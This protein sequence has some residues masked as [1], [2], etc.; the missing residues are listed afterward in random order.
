MN[1][2]SKLLI[3]SFVVLNIYNWVTIVEIRYGIPQI[4]KYLLSVF[5]LGVIFYYWLKHR[6][7]SFSGGM[8]KVL[9]Y[10]LTFW[11]IILLLTAILEFDDIFYV[12]RLL[13]QRFFYIPYILPLLLLFSKF[14]LIFFR[15]YFNLSFLF[16]SIATLMQVYIMMSGMDRSHWFEQTSRIFI[17][18][19]GAGCLLLTSH[20]TRKKYVSYL[21]VFYIICFVFIWTFFGRRGMLVE[22]SLLLI[23]MVVIRLRSDL[24]TRNDRMKIYLSGLIL[25][26]LVIGLGYLFTETYAFQRGFNKSAFEESRGLVFDDFFSDFNTAKDWMIGRGLL[27]TVRRSILGNEDAGFIENGFL[28]ILLKGGLLYA[29]PFIIILL[30]ASFLGIFRS[31]NELC[32]GLGFLIL[33]HVIM[34]GYFNLPDFS[35]KY[36][37]IWISASSLLDVRFRNLNNEEISQSLNATRF[38]WQRN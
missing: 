11:S 21:A 10:I 29:L 18:D 35:P 9:I 27:G 31:N 13:A 26:L 28:N 16:L 36:I 12:Q 7:K 37:M 22:Y 1:K 24:L 25:V 34:M 2:D 3:L 20:L 23:I 19:I 5:V 17:F 30:R 33:L 15:N 6:N 14:D 38:L 4:V 32:S 8:S